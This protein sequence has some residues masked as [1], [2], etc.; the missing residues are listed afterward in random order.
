MKA[1]L[2]LAEVDRLEQSAEFLRDRLLVHLL[3]HLGCRVSEALGITVENIDFKKSTV[4]IEHLKARINLACPQCGARLSKIHKFCPGCGQKI[5]KAI[6]QEKE[7][8]RFRSLPVD[9]ETMTMLK[10]YI[11]RGGPESKGGR[12][13]LFGIS[14]HRAWQIITECANKAGLSKLE[15]TESGKRH[16]VSPHRLRDAFAVHAV[17]LNDSGDGLR[18]LQQHLGHSSITT[19]MKYR[20]VSG[21]EQKEWYEKLW[22]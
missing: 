14:R 11:K 6:E 22:A 7:H 3:F 5:D 12:N 13:L 10:E 15:N 19:T 20:K 9:K 21:E 18:L 2:E 16:N 17:K 8:R 1:Y 4:T